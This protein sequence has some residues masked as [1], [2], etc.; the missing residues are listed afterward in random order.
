MNELTQ[1]DLEEKVLKRNPKLAQDIKN[2]EKQIKREQLFEKAR[3]IALYLGNESYVGCFSGGYYVDIF[4]HQE[5]SPVNPKARHSDEEFLD[6]RVL[7]NGLKIR[8]VTDVDIRNREDKDK[9]KLSYGQVT[10]IYNGQECYDETRHNNSEIGKNDLGK[11]QTGEWQEILSRI[12]PLAIAAKSEL[13]KRTRDGE[14]RLLKSQL[15]QTETYLR[16]RYGL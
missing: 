2:R 10:V 7:P 1:E 11:F 5:G 4:F 8:F 9:L 15:E 14:K 6:N 3:D 16:S 13:Q 12:S